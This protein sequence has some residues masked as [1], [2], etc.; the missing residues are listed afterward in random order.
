[1]NGFFALLLLAS[2]VG[3]AGARAIPALALMPATGDAP[4]DQRTKL[5]AAL[6]KAS[7]ADASYTLIS[8]KEI[9]AQIGDL[10]EQGTICTS[11]DVPCLQR[12]GILLGADY[13]LVP[14]AAGER[15]L[16]A[17]IMLLG[18]E[19]DIG[20]VRTVTGSVNLA[21]A[22]AKTLLLEALHGKEE[23]EVDPNVADRDP[24]APDPVKAPIDKTGDPLD[25]T[26]LND[27]QFAGAA[28]ASVGGGLG[29]LAL[30][31][32]LTCEAVFWTGSGP[33]ATRKDVVAPLGS[34]LW[35]GTIVG[36]AAA[37]AG[38]G[39]FLAGA[40]PAEDGGLAAVK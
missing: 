35:V 31:G 1:M 18:V 24:L 23:P 25:E 36:V 26:K 11:T 34:V 22:T 40:P 5:D 6:R 20:V 4:R 15:E 30:L 7:I 32:A 33:A 17:S 8:A 27:L 29:V 21:N 37:G 14:Q 3:A 12:L 38:A 28:V 19:D 39:V 9:A 10:A 16:E 13:L 2:V